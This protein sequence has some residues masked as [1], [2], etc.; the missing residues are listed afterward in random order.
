MCML[1]MDK[2]SLKYWVIF[3]CCLVIFHNFSAFEILKCQLLC[4]MCIVWI[5]HILIATLSIKFYIQFQKTAEHE[6]KMSDSKCMLP[7]NIV[8]NLMKLSSEESWV[9]YHFLLKNQ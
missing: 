8:I 6:Q 1:I 4:M 3:S 5:Q 2:H 7:E 9:K